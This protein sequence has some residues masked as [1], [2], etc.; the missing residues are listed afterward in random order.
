MSRKLITAP[1]AEPILLADAKLHL[2]VTGSSEDALISLMIAAAREECENEIRRALITQT[3]E[4]YLDNF[5]GDSAAHWMSW[6][7]PGAIELFYPPLQSVT[8]I[9]YI[10]AAG[11]SQVLA[12]TEYTVDDKQ[13]PAWIVPAELKFWPLTR[14]VIN[15]VTVQFV[16]GYGANETFIPK[17]IKNWLLIRI[18]DL[19]S[20]RGSVVMESGSINVASVPQRFT[21]S[22]LDRYRISPP[23]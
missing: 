3:W 23:L 19:F 22:L 11:A 16:C 2:K 1:A 7:S 4:K 8:S 6:G 21:D 14:C 20:N 18:G 5:P 15:A 13:E 10:D 9:S 12:S 17:A